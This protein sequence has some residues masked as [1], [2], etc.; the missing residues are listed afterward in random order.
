MNKRRSPL[1]DFRKG[2]DSLYKNTFLAVV[3]LL[4][5]PKRVY[6]A[7]DPKEG[8]E[9][10]GFVWF[11]GFNDDVDRMTYPEGNFDLYSELLCHFICDVPKE[12]N[13]PNLP[14]GIDVIVMYG[15]IENMLARYH[16]PRVEEWVGEW[17]EKKANFRKVMPPLRRCRS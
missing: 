10:A 4:A 7:Y 1:H 17:V 9:V 2:N 14:I 12:L 13:A 5:D 6:P 15:D 3:S 11:Q 16:W 8:H